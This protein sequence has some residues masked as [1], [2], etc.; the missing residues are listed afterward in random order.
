ML[1]TRTLL[2]SGLLMAAVCACVIEEEDSRRFDDDAT[3]G[4]AGG[5]DAVAATGA[6]AALAT[7]TTSTGAGAASTTSSS[8]TGGNPPPPCDDPYDEPNDSQSTATDLGAVSDCTD[9]TQ[10]DGV[11]DGNDEDWFT[12]S[13][14]DDALCF[15]APGR[16][17]MVEGGQ[18][19]VCKFVSCDGLELTCPEDSSYEESPQGTP[20]CCSSSDV[21][22]DINC[23][24]LSD[25]ATVWIRIDKPATF[26]CVEYSLTFYY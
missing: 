13:G 16:Q 7:S 9:P 10:V 3:T 19:R 2:A 24:G 1:I 5:G 21:E 6:G 25:D 11:L 22:P 15:V 8:S 26:A 20:G 14:S 17:L 4:A 23:S 18:A 12:Y